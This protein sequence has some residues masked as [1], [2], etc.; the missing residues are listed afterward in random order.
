MYVARLVNLQT[1]SYILKHNWREQKDETESFSCGFQPNPFDMRCICN[2]PVTIK[3]FILEYINR[4]K[5]CHLVIN[6]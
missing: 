6:I 4:S 1:I 5:R 2:C 3:Q